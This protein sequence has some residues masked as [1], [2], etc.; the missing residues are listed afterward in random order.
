MTLFSSDWTQ[1]DIEAVLMADDP[2][3]LLQLPIVVGMNAGCLDRQWAE[4]VCMRLARHPHFQVRANALLG[5]GHIARTCRALD[6]AAVLPLIAGG[7][8]DVH[9][10]VRAHASAA[11]SELFIYLDVMVPGFEAEA[12]HFVYLQW[13]ADRFT[14]SQITALEADVR[15]WAAPLAEVDGHE[16]DQEGIDIL[17]FSADPVGT[18]L[19]L[20]PQLLN[21]AVLEEMVVSY[22]KPGWDR[23]IVLWPEK[24]P[25]LKQSIG[26]DLADCAAPA[27]AA[28]GP[29]SMD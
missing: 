9:E 7:R 6:V 14:A 10:A 25:V 23:S 29:G 13:P 28:L 21:A 19:S 17:L 26:E 12:I 20:K 11:A 5:F 18:F 27:S 22:R 8:H 3:K 2:I 1:D 15:R 4:S 16:V 24:P